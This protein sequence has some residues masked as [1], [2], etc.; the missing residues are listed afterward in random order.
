MDYLLKKT[1]QRLKTNFTFPPEDEQNS[2]QSHPGDKKETYF[3]FI[4]FL[5][6]IGILSLQR[7]LAKDLRKNS[8]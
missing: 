2:H 1:P 8:A 3:I 4:T 6:C 7:K 5:E